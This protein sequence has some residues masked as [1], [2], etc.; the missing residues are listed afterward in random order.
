MIINYITELFFESSFLKSNCCLIRVILFLVHVPE[1][2]FRWIN[3]LCIIARWVNG[4]T[5]AK[6]IFQKRPCE[7]TFPCN[8]QSSYKIHRK[9]FLSVEIFYL[10]LLFSY[11]EASIK[12]SLYINSHVWKMI[13]ELFVVPWND[14]MFRRRSSI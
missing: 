6:K 5:V 10:C 4:L 1:F 7:K 9:Y 12:N 8:D 2:C 13:M 14:V 11:Y 3:K